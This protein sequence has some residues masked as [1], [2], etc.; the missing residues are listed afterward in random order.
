MKKSRR[1]RVP[2]P[3]VDPALCDGCGLC[4]KVCP[5]G[6]LAL[7]EGKAVVVDPARCDYE[8]LGEMICP[9]GAIQLPF[10]IVLAP[11]RRRKTGK[12]RVRQ[13]RTD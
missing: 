2:Q 5:A 11:G 1:G 6:A 8:G 7:R 4:V 10:E 3:I 13:D 9:R 12:A